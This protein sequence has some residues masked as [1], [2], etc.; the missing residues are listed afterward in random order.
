ME[1]EKPRVS[2]KKRHRAR[3]LKKAKKTIKKLEL[4]IAEKRGYTMFLKQMVMEE[5]TVMGTAIQEMEAK[6][7]LMKMKNEM[8]FAKNE[9]M[10]HFIASM[11]AIFEVEDALA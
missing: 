8:V 2:M 9:C 5:T 10:E 3:L 6:L 4:K 7:A 11:L 1:K